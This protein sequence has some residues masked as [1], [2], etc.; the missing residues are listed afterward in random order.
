MKRLRFL[1]K[2]NNKGITLTEVFIALFV[3]VVVIDAAIALDIV[4]E[5]SFRIGTAYMDM[6]TD[7]RTA[8][9]WMVRDLR[10]ARQIV[11]S[12][13]FGGTTLTTS[14]NCVVFDLPSL[15]AATGEVIDGSYDFIGYRRNGNTVER[16][17]DGVA[18]T[19]R[20]DETRNLARDCSALDFSSG[21]V[22]LGS[23][24]LG[25]VD[26]VTVSLTITKTV[27]SLGTGA[28][29]NINETLTSQVK[30]RNK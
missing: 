2:W 10:W 30:L 15:N 25:S 28:N 12:H 19:R 23:V 26:D 6:H 11:A 20:A 13:A 5:R 14:D 17:V 29:Q 21:G 18:G 16:R 4:Y 3:M 7:S 9:D 27:R 22:G 24:S 1:N 8:T